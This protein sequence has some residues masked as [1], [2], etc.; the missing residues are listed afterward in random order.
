MESIL[1]LSNIPASVVDDV[2]FNPITGLSQLTIWILEVQ[3][4]RCRDAVLRISS[5]VFNMQHALHLYWL[6]R[7]YHFKGSKTGVT[8]TETL[9]WWNWS[10]ISKMAVQMWTDAASD[11]KPS[12]PK[13]FAI[14]FCISSQSRWLTPGP[15]GYLSLTFHPLPVTLGRSQPIGWLPSGGSFLRPSSHLTAVKPITCAT[16]D[17]LASRISAETPDTVESGLR[18]LFISSPAVFCLSFF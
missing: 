18:W 8:A 17:T 14:S 5:V 13:G 15:F 1:M 3:L 12:P 6:Y 9:A 2:T 7:L 10:I 11:W 4:H 16:H